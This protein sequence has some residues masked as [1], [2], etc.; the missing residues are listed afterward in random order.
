MKVLLL[1]P[2]AA[3]ALALAAP[4]AHADNSDSQVARYIAE[5]QRRGVSYSTPDAAV[6]LGENVCN[7]QAGV[8]VNDA[9]GTYC[10]DS[11]GARYWGIG[12]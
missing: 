2:L 6:N 10:P 1:A 4:P 12:R 7:A 3:I 8:L 11:E 9:I 5:L